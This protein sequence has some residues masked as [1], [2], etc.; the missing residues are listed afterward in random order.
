MCWGGVASVSAITL[1]PRHKIQCTHN[2]KY[3][4]NT[5]QIQLQLQNYCVSSIWWI[6]INL[7]KFI[8][9]FVFVFLAT[10]QY[11]SITLRTDEL[12]LTNHKSPVSDVFVLVFVFV[13]VFLAEIQH[14]SIVVLPC[15][16]MSWVSLTISLQYLMLGSVRHLP[17]GGKG[18][19]GV[20]NQPTQS[21]S[22]PLW[23]KS[24]LCSSKLSNCFYNFVICIFVV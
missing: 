9:K 6:L 3:I 14:C 7:Y 5:K 22:S 10:L 19:T 11:C 23:L 24:S 2:W 15:A 17:G 16:Q 1:P 21:S 4:T 18:F 20:C 13:F 8:Y 12:S